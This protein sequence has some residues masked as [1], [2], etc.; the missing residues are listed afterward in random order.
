M[1][2]FDQPTGPTACLIETSVR[3]QTY[4]FVNFVL[5]IYLALSETTPKCPGGEIF[6]VCCGLLTVHIVTI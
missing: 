3:R 1:R 5:K 4:I 2:T 6:H